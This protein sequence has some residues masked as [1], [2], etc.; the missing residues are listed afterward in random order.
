MIR[1]RVILPLTVAF[2]SDVVIPPNGLVV[3]G[4]SEH[5]S[6]EVGD[7]VNVTCSYG[8]SRPNADLELYINDMKVN[9]PSFFLGFQG[10]S[11]SALKFS[12]S[13]PE[14]T[15]ELILLDSFSRCLIMPNTPWFRIHSMTKGAQW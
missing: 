2:C 13:E 7:F 5:R 8:P 11:L 14:R 10:P 4:V 6:Y 12:V 3:S 1:V 15:L 9:N